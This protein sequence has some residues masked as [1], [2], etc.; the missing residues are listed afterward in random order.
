MLTI[1]FDSY[2]ILVGICFCQFAI[3]LLLT[4]DC[5][6]DWIFFSVGKENNMFEV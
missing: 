3:V 6:Y 2:F 4:V 5:R 1:Y